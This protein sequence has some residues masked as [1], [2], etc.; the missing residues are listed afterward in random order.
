MVVT[1]QFQSN[2]IGTNDAESFGSARGPHANLGVPLPP[3]PPPPRRQRQQGQ[4]DD[5]MA[6]IPEEVDVVNTNIVDASSNVATAAPPQPPPAHVPAAQYLRVRIPPPSQPSLRPSR[7]RRRHHSRR[8]SSND[9][10][11]GLPSAPSSSTAMRTMQRSK[12]TKSPHRNEEEEG[13][14]VLILIPPNGSFASERSLAECLGQVA[15]ST[16]SVFRGDCCESRGGDDDTDDDYSVDEFYEE[17]IQNVAVSRFAHCVSPRFKL[18]SNTINKT[19]IH[20][21]PGNVP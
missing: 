6:A 1:R 4:P 5:A 11:K 14:V 18:D 17:K 15:C 9:E 12:T 13:E 7:I 2:S 8:P 19:D 20:S 16:F 10:N 21:H 3:P